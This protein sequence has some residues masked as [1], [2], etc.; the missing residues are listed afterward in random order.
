MGKEKDKRGMP[1]IRHTFPEYIEGLKYQ[2]KTYDYSPSELADQIGVTTPAVYQWLGGVA[3][4]NRK[5]RQKI[6]EMFKLRYEPTEEETRAEEEAI[7]ESQEEMSL[8]T[9]TP[10]YKKKVIDV[11]W[12][13]YIFMKEMCNRMGISQNEYINE[14]IDYDRDGFN[15]HWR[16]LFGGDK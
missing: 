7:E 8:D 9:G 14:L 13:N 3:R 2:M 4:P 15:R 10:I 5:N 16:Q 12:E 6:E 1:M 11:N